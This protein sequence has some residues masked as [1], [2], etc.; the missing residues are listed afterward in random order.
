MLLTGLDL[1]C[2]GPLAPLFYYAISHDEALGRQYSKIN[3]EYYVKLRHGPFLC[4]LGRKFE[5]KN[6]LNLTEELLFVCVFG[7]HLLFDKKTDQI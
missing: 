5:H 6:G 2:T 3:I 7:P 4:N 1:H